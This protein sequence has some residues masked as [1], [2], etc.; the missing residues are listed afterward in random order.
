MHAR[1]S[2]SKGATSSVTFVTREPLILRRHSAIL[3]SSM[4]AKLRTRNAARLLA[5]LFICDL[6]TTRGCA[7]YS[8]ARFAQNQLLVFFTFYTQK[9]T[10][11]RV[12][13]PPP[14][15]FFF[16]SSPHKTNRV[17]SER[18]GCSN[19]RATSNKSTSSF[20]KWRNTR[21][22]GAHA[23]SRGMS[24]LTLIQLLTALPFNLLTGSVY[25]EPGH[26]T[27]LKL[28]IIGKFLQ[29][30]TVV[31]AWSAES[32]SDLSSRCRDARDIS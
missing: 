14:L 5:T 6:S 7:T 10:L 24:E 9:N 25:A 20:L 27:L 17:G 11:L 12:L 18:Y 1:A 15:L 22:V 4:R 30:H 23:R 28:Q 21:P 31:S 8:R 29:G 16:L 3:R 13:F 26:E 19:S 32:R 2:S